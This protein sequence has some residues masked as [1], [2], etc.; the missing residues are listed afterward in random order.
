MDSKI[1]GG[2]L[3]LGMA[4]GAGGAKLL[5]YDAAAASLH[6][7]FQNEQTWVAQ[8][9]PDA[10]TLYGHRQCSYLVA[11][12]G[13][14]AGEPCSDSVLSQDQALAFE[15]YVATLDAGN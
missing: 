6:T 2:I 11:A 8:R 13:G 7:R 10:G 5:Q 15:A 4:L 12:D 1:A 9:L 3:V 14:R